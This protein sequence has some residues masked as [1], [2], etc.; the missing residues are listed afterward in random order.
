MRCPACQRPLH[1]FEAGTVTLDGC[2]GGCGGIWFDHK[3]LAKVTRKHSKAAIKVADIRPDPNVRVHDDD[4]RRCPHCKGRT[5]E[6]KLYSLGSG[7]IMD[8]CPKCQGLWLDHGELG[9]IRDALHPRPLVHRKI[10]RKT[11][12][13]STAINLDMVQ[14]VQ[15]LHLDSPARTVR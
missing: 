13:D 15:M 14:Q 4:I 7:V 6:K 1:R 3:E 12:S 2:D 8:V 9:K 11:A 5:L 10:D